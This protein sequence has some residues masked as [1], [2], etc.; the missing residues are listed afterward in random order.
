MAQTL[1][2]I[3]LATSSA[4][5]QTIAFRWPPSPHSSPR[6]A[7]PRPSSQLN[8]THVDAPYRAATFLNVNI[9]DQEI[10]STTSDNF[11]FEWQRP[12]MKRFRSHSFA[13]SKRSSS[14][15][16]RS[17]VAQ[18]SEHASLMSPPEYDTVLGYNVDL[19]AHF[20]CP[21]KNNCHQKFELIVDDLVFIGH[22]VCV[23]ESGKWSFKTEGSTSPGRLRGNG[24]DITSEVGVDEES[25]LRSFHIVF[26]LDLPDPSSSASGNINKYF[27]TIYRTVVFSLTAVLFNEQVLHKYVE[28]EWDILVKVKE[29]CV[30]NGRQFISCFLVRS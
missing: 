28:R 13:S 1:L 4:K 30:S 19:L 11:E 24:D 3:L 2:A 20:L 27:D 21:M 25:A 7:R 26:V 17:P 23:D 15:G 10:F 16:R 6:L 18:R 12:S 22:P 14:G 29:D 5:D 8:L 9:K